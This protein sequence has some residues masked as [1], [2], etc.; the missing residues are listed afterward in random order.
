MLEGNVIEH[1][2]MNFYFE[3]SLRIQYKG[4]IELLPIIFLILTASVLGY[5]SACS[6]NIQTALLTFMIL[7]LVSSVA[8]RNNPE[9]KLLWTA[10]ILKLLSAFAYLWVFVV[11]YKGTSDSLGYY[12][13]ANQV[14]ESI[15]RLEKP[16]LEFKFGSGFIAYLTGCIFL[17]I[18]TNLYAGFLIYSWLSFIGMYLFYKGFKIAF[19]YAN[20]KLYLYLIFF[21]PS[22]V[23]W[24]SQI[25]KDSLMFFFL[26]LVAYSLASLFVRVRFRELLYLLIGLFS[27]LLTRPEIAVI[28]AVAVLFSIISSRIGRG[29]SRIAIS[30]ILLVVCYFIF[31]Q[32]MSFMGIAEISYGS[33][34]DKIQAESDVNY[35]GGS[36]F[37]NTPATSLKQLPINVL[38]SLIRPLPWEV[39]NYLAFIASLESVLMFVLLI[40]YLKSILSAIANLMNNRYIIFVVS[41]SFLV[42]IGLSTI[43]NLGLLV[44]QRVQLL[45]FFFML[46]SYSKQMTA[47]LNES[48]SK[49]A[50]DIES[51]LERSVQ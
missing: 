46:I 44:R 49:Q 4:L 43:A 15:K 39:R 20:H 19:P 22:I 1:C 13:S 38:N 31:I 16:D 7:L 17:I 6:S 45:P 37:Q 23:F 50:L 21:F 25:G 47:E 33:V 5:F 36:K 18:G 35:I 30:L 14:T 32:S 40:R 42:V 8:F 28:T 48:H 9:A 10:L 12:H 2:Q 27:S 11:Y 34:K 24:T 51:Q 29:I 26:G 3:S 41:Y